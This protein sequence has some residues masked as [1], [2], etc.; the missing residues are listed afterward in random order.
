M[1]GAAWDPADLEVRLCRALDI[2]K[3]AIALFA[4]DGYADAEAPE[5]SFR[6]DKIVA[7][8]A[9]LIYAASAVAHR[10]EVAGRVEELARILVPHARSRRTLLNIALHSS[11]CI[12]FAFPHVLLTRLG[13]RD[14]GFDEFLRCCLASR[15]RHGHERPAFAAAEKMWIESLWTGEEPGPAWRRCMRD[16][17]LNHPLDILGGAREDAYALT[18]LFMYC[19]DFGFRAPRL[20][21]SRSVILNEAASQLAKCLDGE[22]YDLA[23]ELI[24]AWPLSGTPWPAAAAFGFRVLA[25]VEDQIGVLPGGTTDVGRLG[26]LQG[27]AKDRYALGTAYHTAYVMGMI[28]AASLRPN[29]APPTRITGPR[30]DESLLDRLLNGIDRDQGHWQAELLK[31][32][33]SQQLALGPLLLDLAIAQKYRKHDYGGIGDLLVTASRHGLARSA[34]CGQA[35]ELLQRLSAFAQAIE[36]GAADAVAASAG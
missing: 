32:K 16:T 6:P 19:T 36:P 34:L 4:G 15:S 2:A 17:V 24:L 7:E 10:P 11:L 20:P 9:M 28:C 33:R 31:L 8:T 30:C 26:K 22:D 3:R 29:R 18:H 23:G 12:D 13:Y 27:D 25:Y 1:G 14:R 5:T 21:R 35:A